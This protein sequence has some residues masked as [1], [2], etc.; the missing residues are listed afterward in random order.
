MTIVSINQLH[1]IHSLKT[2]AEI[3]YPIMRILMTNLNFKTNRGICKMKKRST[4]GLIIDFI[5]VFCTGGAWLIWIVIR[6]LR[7][8]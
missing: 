6:Y 7:N 5:L 3:T 2:H 1:I 8:R 4:F